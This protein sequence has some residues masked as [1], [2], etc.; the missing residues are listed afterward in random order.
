MVKTP[1]VTDPAGL[2]IPDRINANFGYLSVDPPVVTITAGQDFDLTTASTTSNVYS[3]NQSTITMDTIIGGVVGEII[4]IV[5]LSVTGVITIA[6]SGGNI[7]G[8]SGAIVLGNQY[9]NITLEKIDTSNWVVLSSSGTIL[10]ENIFGISYGNAKDGSSNS[11]LPAYDSGGIC[12]MG[13]EYWFDSFTI[14]TDITV[15]AAIGWLVI[16][17]NTLIVSKVGGALITGTGKGGGNTPAGETGYSFFV[18]TYSS[19]NTITGVPLSGRII[20]PFTLG[21]SAPSGTSGTGSI[22]TNQMYP[23]NGVSVIT[24]SNPLVNQSEVRNTFFNT[25]GSVYSKIQGVNGSNAPSLSSNLAYSFIKNPIGYGQSGCPGG[26]SF[27]YVSASDGNGY[28]SNAGVGG[29]SVAGGA[30]IAIYAKNI[31]MGSNNLSITSN[32]LTG[33]VGVSGTSPNRNASSGSSSGSGAGC[34]GISYITKSGT[35][36]FTLTNTGGAASPTPTAETY[37]QGGT[38]GSGANGL[39]VI[40]DDFAKKISINGGAFLPA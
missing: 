38:G 8:M 12:V 10:P 34:I 14:S 40:V 5:N 30:N 33:L 31:S 11:N 29:A 35:G 25:L 18:N 13:G 21:I 24:P 1:R 17:A 2:M 27:L 37:G 16:R 39:K 19:G 20:A 7:K 32:G 6:S 22:Y 3:V 23:M 15:N 28:A 26:G 4:T 36:T 9:A